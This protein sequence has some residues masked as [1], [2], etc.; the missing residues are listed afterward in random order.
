MTDITAGNGHDSTGGLEPPVTKARA[1]KDPTATSRA[2][3]YRDARGA[4]T[5][6]VAENQNIN[7]FNTSVTVERDA[8]LLAIR[9][10]EKPS[11]KPQ[12]SMRGSR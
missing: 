1:S 7:D 10:G 6:T 3:R 11:G 5:I 8:A 4:V 9:D 2:K 12:T